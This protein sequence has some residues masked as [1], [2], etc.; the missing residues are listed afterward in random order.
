MHSRTGVYDGGVGGGGDWTCNATL[1]LENRSLHCTKRPDQ[2]KI[3]V[4][5]N[6]ISFLMPD[7]V[8]VVDHMSIIY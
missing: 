8:I 4:A 1:V 3:H 7:F 2:S 5:L 6:E